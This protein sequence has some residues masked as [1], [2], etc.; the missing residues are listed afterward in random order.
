MSNVE[1]INRGDA[2]ALL[3]EAIEH[4][5]KS[6]VLAYTTKDGKF[7]TVA[8]GEMYEGARLIKLGLASQ[9]LHDIGDS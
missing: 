5:P 4:D 7:R 9:L 3:R 2:L 8:S 6:L 1:F